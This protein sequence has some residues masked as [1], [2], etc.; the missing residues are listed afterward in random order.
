[1]VLPIFQKLMIADGVTG[2]L[3][4]QR[5]LAIGAIDYGILMKKYNIKIFDYKNI[6]IVF[7]KIVHKIS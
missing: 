5:L 6:E 1:M 3:V 7:Y 4:H 2:L